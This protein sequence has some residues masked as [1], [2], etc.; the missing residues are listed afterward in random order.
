[1]VDVLLPTVHVFHAANPQSRKRVNATLLCVSLSS[2]QNTPVL[3]LP[4]RLPLLERAWG[5]EAH[6]WQLRGLCGAD[7][8]GPGTF[9]D[10][11]GEEAHADWF[12]GWHGWVQKRY[13][14]SP[15]RSAGLAAQP[16]RPSL[17]WNWDLSTKRYVTFSIFYVICKLLQQIQVDC[18][19]WRPH[20]VNSK[21]KKKTTK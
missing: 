11:R 20:S 4:G 12:H 7:F 18:S 5:W 3:T 17:A 10:L 6:W 9:I 2:L 13:H 21:V 8:A 14:K 1:M 15:L 19:I 16:S